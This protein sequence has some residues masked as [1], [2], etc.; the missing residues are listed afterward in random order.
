MRT[1]SFRSSFFLL[2]IVL[3]L[4]DLRPAEAADSFT[5]LSVK[6]NVVEP[7][8]LARIQE[9]VTTGI[10]LPKS[11]NVLDLNTF[12]IVAADGISTVPAQFQAMARWDGLVS[13]TTKPL[14]W[15]LIDFQAD[16]AANA[17]A[18]Y[19]LKIGG[20][21][22]ASTGIVVTTATDLITIATGSATFTINRTAFNLFDTVDLGLGPLVNHPSNGL[23][24]NATSGSYSSWNIAP[25]DVSVETAG[26]LHTVVRVRGKLSTGSATL[27]GGSAASAFGGTAQNLELEYSIRLHFYKGKSFVRIEQTLINDGNGFNGSWGNNS[28]YAKSLVLNTTLNLGASHALVLEG[29]TDNP[30]ITDQYTFLQSHSVVNATA[31]SQNFSYTI[32]KNGSS[33]GTGGTRARGFVD[34]GDGTQGL[35]LAVRYFWQNFPKGFR[36]GG[37]GISVDLLP[38]TGTSYTL[39][40]G[41]YKTH[42]LLFYFHTGSFAGAGSDA[43]VTAFQNPLAVRADP[44]WYADTQALGLTA[45]AG[46]TSTDSQ[47]QEAFDRFEQLQRIKY[48]AAEASNA[49]SILTYR[50][51]RMLGGDWYG[52]NDFGDMRWKFFQPGFMSGVHYDWPYSLQLHYLRTGNRPFLD[53][54][55][56]MVT[57]MADF[58]I[59][60]GIAPTQAAWVKGMAFWE[61]GGHHATPYTYIGLMERNQGYC[62][63]YF[64]TGA[65]RYLDTCK[66]AADNAWSHW[67]TY[68]STAPLYQKSESRQYGW[69]ILRLLTYYKTSGDVTYLNNALTVFTNGL[70]ANEQSAPPPTGIGSSGQGYVYD[71]INSNDCTT[72]NSTTGVIT[73]KVRVLMM[74]Y[75]TEPLTELHRL[76]GSQAVQDFLVRMLEFVRT[77]TYVGG[78]TNAAGNYLPHQAPYCYNPATGSR[79]FRDIQVIYNYL[80][81]S[82]YAYLHAITGDTTYRDFARGLFKDSILYWEAVSNT[83]VSPAT[84]T[85]VYLGYEPQTS[86]QHGWIGRFHQGYLAMEYQMQKNGGVLPTWYPF[87]PPA[88]GGSGGDAVPPVPPTGLQAQ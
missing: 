40:G 79:E 22:T 66:L 88:T 35:T 13:D 23:T 85:P 41:Q 2:I 77:K 71:D 67:T 52:W 59:H 36:V 56:E 19:Y 11:A 63:A 50:E 75:I 16:V 69:I 43:Q 86:K 80:F 33:F 45:P 15:V 72:K 37:S 3:S 5:P 9:P 20:T 76:T 18:T 38:D 61:D 68:L 21:G 47:R 7:S 28:L 34:L 26:P 10:P 24:L 65:P 54:G 51:T 62:L 82:G 39:R 46:L 14:K 48:N 57:H 27:K 25:T 87:S 49:K 70:L 32:Q 17:I 30:T 6:L 4:A 29:A 84:R 31:E 1:V 44:S 8:G 78:V 12:R 55:M 83:Y 73:Y 58:D 42:E 64:L 53:L 60:H 74:G 81:A